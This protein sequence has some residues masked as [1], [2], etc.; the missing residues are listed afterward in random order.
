MTKSKLFLMF[1]VCFIFTEMSVTGQTNWNKT[2]G[3]T[4]ND[5]SV[6]LTRT[7][8]KGYIITGYTG[9]KDKDFLDMNKGSYDIFVIKYDS[10]DR[11]VWKKNIG[12][13]KDDYGLN[14]ISSNDGGCIVTGGT[15]SNDGDFGGMNKGGEDIFVVKLNGQG[16]IVWKKLYGGNKNDICYSISSTNDNGYI[17]TGLTKS[18]DGDFDGYKEFKDYNDIFLI[19]IDSLGNL[20]WVKVFGGQGED[21]GVSVFQDTNNEFVLTG[22]SSSNDGVFSGLNKFL[23]DVFVFKLDSLGNILWKKSIGGRGYDQVSQL[24]PY[25][26]NGFILT[27][28]TNSNTDDFREMIKG[29]YDVFVIRMDSIGNIIWKKTFGG[30]KSEESFCISYTSNGD[31]LLVGNTSSNN[32]DFNGMNR[33]VNTNDIFLIKLDSLGELIWKKT[34]GGTGNDQ[35]RSLEVND[36]GNIYVTGYTDSK[37]GDFLGMTNEWYFDVY[38]M[39]L[40]SNGNLNNTTSINEFSEPT[41]TLSVHPNP[42]SNSTTIS[43]IV[44]TPSNISIEL[45]N[46]LGQTIEVLRND[47]SDSGTYQLPLNVSNLTSGM[48][49]VRMRSGS[50]SMVVPVWVVK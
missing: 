31:I 5:E 36:N 15:L 1:F 12:G 42:F 16:K 6:S 8:D 43:Y 22:H 18:Q 9:S 30:T 29:E 45:L 28:K 13:W 3:G 14:V 33:L 37:D 26:N 34:Y 10:N 2:I 23:S 40:D 25:K 21:I 11:E 48:Y 32:G 47:Y 38:F 24:K 46:T 17:L 50:I 44:E 27:G 49:S 7:S 35:G 20:L 39:K 41:T 4:D 19:K